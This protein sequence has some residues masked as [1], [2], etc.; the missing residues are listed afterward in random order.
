MAT[1]TANILFTDVEE[2]TELRAQLG[3]AAADRV[4]VDLERLLTKLV[5]RQHGRVVKTAGDGIMAAFDA[6]S[7]AV[8]AAVAMQ[9]AVARRSEGLRIR[10]GI[11]A[12]DVSWENNDCFGL[13]VVTA[14]RLENAALGGQILVSQVVRLLAGERSEAA[15]EPVG[16]LELKGLP[17]PVEAFAVGW[18]RPEAGDGDALVPLPPALATPAGF[19]FVGRD[20][21]WDVLSEAWRG[22]LAGGRRVVLLGGEAGAGKTRLASEFVRQLHEDGAAVLFGGCDPQLLF[23]YQPWVQALDHLLRTLAPSELDADVA[24]DLGALA[25]LLPRLDRP[26]APLAP[27]FVDAESERYRMFAAVDGVLAEAARRWPLVIVLDDLHWAGAQTLGLLNYIVRA[28]NTART[29]VVGTFRDTGDEIAG[30]LA[31][32]LADLR[33]LDSVTRLRVGGLNEQDV[34]ALMAGAAGQELDD[35]LNALADAVADRSRGNAFFVGELW[36]HL[37]ASGSVARGRRGWTVERSLDDAGVPDS[38]REVVADRLAHVSFA[39]RRLAELISVGGQRVELR[40][41][42]GAADTTASD[43]TAG[44]DELTAAG[45]VEPVDRPL[46]AYRFTHALV[47]DTVAAAIPAASRA[48]L[49]LRVGEALETVHEVDRRPI[50]A[51]LARHFAEAAAVGAAGKAVYYARRAAEQAMASLGYEEATAHLK[52]VVDLAPPGSR[53]RAEVLFALGEAVLHRSQF[54]EAERWFEEAFHLAREHGE[55]TLAGE[56]ALGFEDAIHS[57]GMPGEPALIMVNE[58]IRLVG[59]DGSSLRARLEA[60][61]AEALTHCGR[62]E[63]ARVVLDSALAMARATDDEA[64]ARALQAALVSETDPHRLLDY[65]AQLQGVTDATGEVW[66][67][68]Y[69]TVNRLRAYVTLGDLAEAKTVLARHYDIVKRSPHPILKVEA[70][71]YEIIFALA[72]GRFDDADAAAEEALQIGSDSH[73]GAAGM[74]G[75]QMF[76]IRRE[77]GRLAEVAP[78]LE[79]VARRDEGSSLWGPGLAVLYAEVDR[80]DD[81]RA[82]FDRL[83]PDNFATVPRDVLWPA[84]AAFLAEVCIAIG[85]RVRAATLTEELLPFQ[86][87]NLAVGYTLCF[88]PA[89]RLLGG[90]AAL[91]GDREAADRYF[92]AALELAERSGAAAWSAHVEHD[93]ARFLAGAGDTRA[94]ALAASALETAETLGMATLADRCRRLSLPKLAAVPSPPE[95]P[96][97]LSA[98]E[99][100]VLRL[101]AAG[102]SNREIGEHL[103]IS[104][105]TAANH[106]RAILQKTAC[107]NRAEAAAYAARNDLLG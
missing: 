80:L 60:A 53:T 32:A 93:W 51:D 102:R 47:G 84:C 49:H 96:H 1:A 22:A 6:A 65:A 34:A 48:Q 83:A 23:P 64:L 31:S 39:A 12:G 15:F 41:L 45:M 74:Y 94:M 59:D 71:C 55:T 29:L 104:P 105:N 9:Q 8:Q 81:A 61:R 95:F 19:D 67:E 82:E 76:A 85:D 5:E 57:P 98:R 88:G 36:R 107:A 18:E 92:G 68:A 21:E 100:E 73:A 99:V 37:V 13:P 27:S 52:R 50:L 97:G 30:P 2:S 38:V 103:M 58:A 42:F 11:A 26:A 40:V 106:V 79:A 54:S 46:L 43:V 91:V 69:V 3:A 56:A 14:A 24:A 7:D 66:Y 10:I 4:F 87:W 16:P 72:E 44:L 35:D 17:Q 63:E 75:L 90:L 86:G 20:A 101:V 78:V 89:D 25:P 77:Q 28:G 70:L 62:A 33:R